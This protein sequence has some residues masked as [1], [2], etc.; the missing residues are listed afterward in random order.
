[1]V[2]ISKT[3]ESKSEQILLVMFNDPEK[4]LNC[5]GIAGLTEMQPQEVM[6]YIDGLYD[7]D[8]VYGYSN[9]PEKQNLRLKLKI[10]LVK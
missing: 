8:F 6:Y 2:G 7:K 5:D 3:L 10:L 1:M 9:A 4:S